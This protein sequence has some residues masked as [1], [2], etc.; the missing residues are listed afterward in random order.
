M[1]PFRDPKYVKYTPILTLGLLE[2][3]NVLQ[4]IHMWS[5]GTSVGQSPWGWLCVNLALLLW[6]N[7]YTVFTPDQKLAIYGTCVGIVL[8]AAVIATTIYLQHP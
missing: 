8:N 2:S 4:L 1:T 6:L 5:T 7:W 3:A